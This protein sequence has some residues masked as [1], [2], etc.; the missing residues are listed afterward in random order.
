M[1]LKKQVYDAGIMQQQGNDVDSSSLRQSMICYGNVTLASCEGQCVSEVTPSVLSY[2]GLDK[3]SWCH[4][5]L[6]HCCH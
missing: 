4:K 6:F 3:V 2:M 5:V 1:L